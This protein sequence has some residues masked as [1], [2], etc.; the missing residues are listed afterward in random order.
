MGCT[1]RQDRAPAIGLLSD[2]AQLLRSKPTA[3]LTN[4]AAGQTSQQES[5]VP[6]AELLSF[7]GRQSVSSEPA[8][9]KVERGRTEGGHTF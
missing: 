5:G 4:T 8:G 3:L 2:V 6:V 7:L 9:D 1:P